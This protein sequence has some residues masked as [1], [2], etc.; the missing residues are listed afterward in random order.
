MEMH[1][2]F[3][4]T[5]KHTRIYHKIFVIQHVISYLDTYLPKKQFYVEY[6]INALQRVLQRLIKSERGNRIQWY[7]KMNNRS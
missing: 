6:L 4:S 1:M 5:V 3:A 2:E 7:L